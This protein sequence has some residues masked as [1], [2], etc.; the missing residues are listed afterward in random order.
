MKRL[1]SSLVC[2][3][4]LSHAAASEPVTPLDFT[5]V[6]VSKL[7]T[8]ATNAQVQITQDLQVSFKDDN[9]KELTVFLDN[10]YAE[11]KLK[12]ANK[13]KVI[14]ICPSIP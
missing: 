14:K 4:G 2:A 1:I 13:S 7:R 12:P 10:A 3:L 11:Y 6:F 5:E 9:G 8:A